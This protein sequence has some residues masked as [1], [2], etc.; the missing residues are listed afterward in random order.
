MTLEKL[1]C[2]GKTNGKHQIKLH[3]NSISKIK[4]ARKVVE[5]II[6]EKRPVYGFNTGFGQFSNICIDNS[7]LQQLQYNL[8]RS[9]ATGTGSLVDLEQTRRTAILRV[10]TLVRGHSG[11]SL[12]TLTTLIKVI[13]ANIVILMPGQGTVFSSVDVVPLSHIALG[14]SERGQ[15]LNKFDF[16]NIQKIISDV[17]YYIVP[18]KVRI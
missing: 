5:N 11:I 7:N 17:F 8:I 15:F 14:T 16:D 13:N 18:L 12:E 9:H 4:T 2:L 3:E 10:N 1:A 6:Q